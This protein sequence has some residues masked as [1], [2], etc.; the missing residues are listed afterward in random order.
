MSI[1]LTQ[2]SIPSIIQIYSQLFKASQSSSSSSLKVPEVIQPPTPIISGKRKSSQ[3]SLSSRGG[4]TPRAVPVLLSPARIDDNITTP[5]SVRLLFR[6]AG[7]LFL[8]ST[9]SF[10][11]I[12]IYFRP[13]GCCFPSFTFELP[14]LPVKVADNLSRSSEPI[15]SVQS[16]FVFY[17]L[18]AAVPS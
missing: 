10:I 16:Y 1:F 6:S 18:S 15:R 8:S 12:F 14:S 13:P 11:F 3:D 2:F 7:T 5:T 9:L 4:S 17:Y